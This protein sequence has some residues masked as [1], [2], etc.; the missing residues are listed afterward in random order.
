MND[1]T[2]S[3]DDPIFEAYIRL[4]SGLHFAIGYLKACP[5]DNS[6]RQ[7]LL[8]ELEA[9]AAQGKG[10]FLQSISETYGGVGDD[11]HPKG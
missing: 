6:V 3:H 8:P 10:K 2:P 7:A 4:S 1:R 11:N 9:A 5:A